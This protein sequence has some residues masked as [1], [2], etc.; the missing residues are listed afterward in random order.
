MSVRVHVRAAIEHHR[1]SALMHGSTEHTNG[2]TQ[3]IREQLQMLSAR[4]DRDA[5]RGDGV[6]SDVPAEG[7][8]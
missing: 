3:E 5:W 7:D 8:H 1:E 2:D 6:G 4:A